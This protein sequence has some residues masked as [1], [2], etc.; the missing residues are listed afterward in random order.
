M[1][2]APANV[3]SP[4]FIPFLYLTDIASPQQTCSAVN[5]RTFEDDICLATGY[6]G[7]QQFRL[8]IPLKLDSHSRRVYD[9][10]LGL[11]YS[12]ANTRQHY[13][14]EGDF[15]IQ[16]ARVAL[17]VTEASFSKAMENLNALLKNPILSEDDLFSTITGLLELGEQ[18]SL[19][20]SRTGKSHL[21]SNQYYQ[22][23]TGHEFLYLHAETDQISRLILHTDVE[24][25]VEHAEEFDPSHAQAVVKQNLTIER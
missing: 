23:S 11:T 2:D 3:Q 5:V 15:F 24:L 16:A 18:Y 10:V 19:N 7:E 12:A 21:K 25:D 14:R 20:I 4:D 1:T 6:N 17:S 9:L 22:C 8:D 13:Q